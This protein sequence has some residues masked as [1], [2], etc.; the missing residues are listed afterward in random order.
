MAPRRP[1][2]RLGRNGLQDLLLGM[3]RLG[4]G[5]AERAQAELTGL[6]A[7]GPRGKC[8]VL[9]HPVPV[10][11]RRPR[12]HSRRVQADLRRSRRHDRA[13]HDPESDFE[14]K[15]HACER[16]CA[17]ERE[18]AP[19]DRSEARETRERVSLAGGRRR[20]RQRKR[21]AL[22]RSLFRL[23][24]VIYLRDCKLTRMLIFF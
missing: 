20:S 9:P 3:F 6:H 12:H 4:L 21:D 24:R 2:F 17:G 15:Y 23:L 19:D 14:S 5:S 13:A 7:T 10:T 16:W 8:H 22:V 11:N 1:R 18:R